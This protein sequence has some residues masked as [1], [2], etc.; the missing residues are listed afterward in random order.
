MIKCSDKFEVKALGDCCIV[1]SKH[2]LSETWCCGMQEKLCWH[3]T[4][5]VVQRIVFSCHLLIA[6]VKKG[7]VTDFFIF[8]LN[9]IFALYLLILQGQLHCFYTVS[10]GPLVHQYS[11][12]AQ[13]E[14]HRN[15]KESRFLTLGFNLWFLLMV[16][17]FWSHQVVNRS[18]PFT[19]ETWFTIWKYCHLKFLKFFFHKVKAF[20]RTKAFLE[21]LQESIRERQQLQ[22]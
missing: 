16:E 14:F 5:T 18:A 10:S 21:S 22:G 7:T 1:H 8:N 19:P 2:S 4:F 12:S 15:W 20:T 9:W 17:F 3:I 11:W 13:T 6:A